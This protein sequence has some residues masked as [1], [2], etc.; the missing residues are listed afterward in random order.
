MRTARPSSLSAIGR[1]TL[2]GLLLGLCPVAAAAADSRRFDLPSGPLD[3]ALLAFGQQSGLDIG[4][5]PRTIAGRRTA[6]ARGS[7]TPRDALTRLLAGTGCRPSFA[8]GATVRIQC[9]REAARRP[10]PEPGA[11]PLRHDPSDIVVTASKQ[12]GRIEDYPGSVLLI[13]LDR[14]A[15]SRTTRGSDA[16]LSLFPQIGSTNL[17]P[18][19]NK[20]F[21]RGIADSS[22]SG[23]TQATVGQYLGDVRLTYNAPD[24]DLNLYDVERVEVL[25]GPQNT[26]Y[27]T[28]ALGGV[29]RIVPHAPSS[30]ALAGSFAG[31]F[32]VTRHGGVGSDLAVMLNI[33]LSHAVAVRLVGYRDVDAGYIDDPGRHLGDI[34]H[35]TSHG[36]RADLRYSPGNGWTVDI[37]GV[38]QNIAMRDGQYALSGLPP[39]TRRSTLA[40][41]F[42]NDYL[43]G[44]VTV[45]KQWDSMELVSA[46]GY[47]D[48]DVKTR[49]DATGS[50]GTTHPRLF[51]E[52]NQLSVLSHETRLAGRTSK[53]ISWV[54]GAAFV[55]ATDEIRRMLGDPAAPTAITGVRND[56][57]EAALFGRLSF[58][59]LRRV[60]LTVGGRGTYADASGHLLAV[61]SEEGASRVR[62]EWSVSPS[63]GL[64]WKAASDLSFFLSYDEGQRAGGLAVSSNGVE[65]TT[66]R[67]EP[68]S[69]SA[70]QG[71]VR[72]GREA[73]GRLGGSVIASYARWKDI[74]ADLIDDAGLPYTANIG[75]GRITALEAQLQWMPLSGLRLAGA[76][77]AADSHL[78][79]LAV[80]RASP[81]HIDLPNVAPWGGRASILY[82]ASLR[83]ETTLA[84]S[85]SVHYV[86]R[87]RLGPPPDLYIPQ[88]NYW[89]VDLGG[90]L[91]F[92]RFGLSLDVTNLLDS[93]SNRFSYGNPFTVRLGNQVTPLRPRSW[94]F[95]IDAAF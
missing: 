20:L 95:G 83:G 4:V 62:H 45:R 51:V 54:A 6:G 15:V 69:M 58:P 59:L 74:Q 3:V 71:G 61:R 92:G 9:A 14:N 53:G 63:V 43:L 19:R 67:F 93:R 26:L 2:A 66:Q 77:F 39:L 37:G 16:A 7:F 75:D 1:L 91:Q 48:Q 33:P 76:L 11:R 56:N 84:L 35:S 65:E 50:D 57:V 78:T 68:D 21:I 87:S 29:F 5:D 90:R 85:G 27:G 12:P 46:T 79:G 80:G 22:F 23:P 60:S 17:G 40:Q 8:D 24:P 10:R 34:N 25:E 64:T 88:G 42:D 94:R 49:F 44:H 32:S 70:V 31:G 89:N 47:V 55:S 86:G 41:P 52:D 72:F 13:P 38:V 81:A 30:K 28:G 36:G 18:G 73:P 82:S